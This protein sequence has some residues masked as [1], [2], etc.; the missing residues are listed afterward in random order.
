[1]SAGSS[2]ITLPGSVL[3]TGWF[4]MGAI[5]LIAFGGEDYGERKRKR[6]TRTPG[7]YFSRWGKASPSALY[8]PRNI[9][10]A[11]PVSHR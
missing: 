2:L 4:R 6:K 5:T 9:R 1:M 8:S 3:Q 11:I 7:G 10:V